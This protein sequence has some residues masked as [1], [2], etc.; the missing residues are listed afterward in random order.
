M[1]ARRFDWMRQHKTSSPD[2]LR[3]ANHMILAGPITWKND[4]ETQGKLQRI[5]STFIINEL[6]HNLY[7]TI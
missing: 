6:S 5:S 2:T 7:I 3:V 1:G 4:D